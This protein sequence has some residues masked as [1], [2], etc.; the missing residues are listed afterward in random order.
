LREES[1]SL[2]IGIRDVYPETDLE[3]LRK[4][5]YYD[6][7]SQQN[8]AT[9]IILAINEV[10][11]WF[12]AEET[13]FQKI[14]KK[15]TMKAVN[16]IAKIDVSKESTESIPHPSFT[17]K[18]IYISGG[19]TYDK[20]AEKVQRTVDTLDYTNLCQNV[21]KRNGSLNE[22]LSCLEGFIP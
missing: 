6:I 13:H 8:I 16:S 17:L 19:T 4:Y 11:S 2:V 14:S 22:L 7:S 3:K 10:E 12:I 5:L 20:S 9:K 21:R 1:F 15:L 18:Q